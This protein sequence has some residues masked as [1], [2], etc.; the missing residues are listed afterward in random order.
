MF[1]MAN[2]YEQKIH[3]NFLEA[4][5]RVDPLHLGSSNVGPDICAYLDTSIVP[6]EAKA[7]KNAQ[8]GGTS[9]RYD[10]VSGSLTPVKPSKHDELIYKAILERKVAMDAY[11]DK[12]GTTCIPLTTTKDKRSELKVSGLQAAIES[13]VPV[14]ISFL[15]DHYNKKGIYY[16]QIGGNGLFFMGSNPHNL[17]IPEIT[18]EMKVELR[19]GYGGGKTTTPIRSAGLRV[20]GRL[21]TFNKSPF[22][23]DNI[24]DIKKL[25]ITDPT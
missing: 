6:I 9:W 24:E 22:T 15:I 21:K 11:L 17:P 3:S 5:I 4:G 23:L 19:L 1:I 14:P 8:M 16:I 20:Q 10:K 12:L 18:G 2:L 7:D 25:F 13:S